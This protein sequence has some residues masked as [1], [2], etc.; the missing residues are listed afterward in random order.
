M[1]NETLYVCLEAINNSDILVGYIG[2]RY[3]TS[4]TGWLDSSI[5]R[6][7]QGRYLFLEKYRDRSVTEIEWQHAFLDNENYNRENK[8]IC[9]FYFRNTSW[10]DEMHDALSSKIPQTDEDR[11]K[12]KYYK[13]E[14]DKSFEMLHSLKQDVRK[15]VEEKKQGSVFNDYENPDEGS[16]LIIACCSKLIKRL[17][18]TIE[19]SSDTSDKSLPEI[20]SKH[21][22]YAKAKA[23]F[24]KELVAFDKGYKDI[25]F[26]YLEGSYR[27]NDE[28]YKEPL[29][30][31][32]ESGTGKS[33][34][35]ASLIE[36]NGVPKTS[37]CLYHFVG[38]DSGS[39]DF[40]EMAENLYRQFF[41]H[42]KPFNVCMAPFEELSDSQTLTI[43]KLIDD[44]C[45]KS[46]NLPSVCILID[47]INEF[48]KDDLTYYP[49][50]LHKWLPQKL[51]YIKLLISCTSN[52]EGL[53]YI[54][55]QVNHVVVHIKR[56]TGDRAQELVQSILRSYHK[57]DAY[58]MR[59]LWERSSLSGFP[60]FLTTALN[61]LIIHGNYDT[62]AGMVDRIVTTKSIQALY[63]FIIDEL[64]KVQFMDTYIDSASTN[65]IL[66]LLYCSREGLT[67]DEIIKLLQEKF[68]KKM[69]DN[70]D[71]SSD[72]IVFAFETY[73]EQFIVKRRNLYNFSHDYVRIAIKE[74]F[75]LEDD[76]E[77]LSDGIAI[78]KVLAEFFA[79]ECN[80]SNTE[81]LELTRPM[82][83]LSYHERKANLRPSVTVIV[84]V[85]PFD[86]N[87]DIRNIESISQSKSHKILRERYSICKMK[88]KTTWILSPY[89]LVESTYK[90]YT[91]DY[92]LNSAN[93]TDRNYIPQDKMYPIC[94][95]NLVIDSLEG[96][97][98]SLFAYGQTGSG[99]T[100]SIFG[101]DKHEHPGLIPNLSKGI[102]Y[103]LYYY[104][105][106][107]LLLLHLLSNR[108]VQKA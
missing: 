107:Q 35:M 78:H 69:I 95:E 67:A 92:S 47:A 59:L 25:V 7:I 29:F 103:L 100:Y 105:Y 13:V 68:N 66:K 15:V 104:C 93:P 87:R 11:K 41:H 16:K 79:K 77:L 57:K 31:S 32:G 14:N 97:N 106:L 70:N 20:S 21:T 27:R 3:G 8:P 82:R 52:Y 1:R 65:Y 83:E 42:A 50:K 49:H 22:A 91:F 48:D 60:L 86:A 10:D 23:L 37:I 46:P 98:G 81:S 56:W 80:N 74:K 62:I 40:K 75:R 9:F 102:I 84:R 33:T 39:K 38:C 71:S 85:R 19:H 76:N 51:K 61:F 6:C 28:S 54:E 108:S 89:E 4:S 101:D 34:F 43:L 72:N 36:R 18:E 5:E 96:F 90:T 94:C 12:M 63:I 45:D 30:V 24:V 88:G 73:L 26:E 44:E 2:A 58:V 53:E 55:Q 99:K 17:L 64:E